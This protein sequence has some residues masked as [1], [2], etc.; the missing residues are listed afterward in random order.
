MFFF[1]SAF[2]TCS[3]RIY[4]LFIYNWESRKNFIIWGH[5]G[6]LLKKPISLFFAQKLLKHICI[7]LRFKQS[8]HFLVVG[9]IAYLREDTHKKSVFFSC[10]STKGVGRGNPPDHWAKIHR[11]WTTKPK[12]SLSGQG[13]ELPPPLLPLSAV[14]K[15]RQYLFLRL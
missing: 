12:S 4:K 9:K 5:V 15:R 3:N 6:C 13:A 11:E 7:F 10:R 8:K 2:I 1:F 14:K